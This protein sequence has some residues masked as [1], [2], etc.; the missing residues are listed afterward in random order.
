[1]SVT[2]KVS[3][4]RATNVKTNS[5]FANENE[6]DGVLGK[7]SKKKTSPPVFVIGSTSGKEINRC[8]TSSFVRSVCEAY[9]QHHNLVFKPDDV[10]LAIMVQFSF[11]LE[12]YAEPLRNKFVSHQGQKQLE[13]KGLGTLSSADYEALS[14]QMSDEIAKHIKDPSVRDWAVPNFSTTTKKEQVVGA[15]TLMATMKK[16]FSY[17]FSL[18]CGLPQ[19]TLLGTA[20]DWKAVEERAKRLLEFDNDEHFMNQWYDML[21]PILQQFTLAAQN[22]PDVEFWKHVCSHH[23]NGSGPRYLSGWITVFCVFN[24]SG[25]WNGTNH[26]RY[27]HEQNKYAPLKGWPMLDTNDIPSGVVKVDVVIDD[28]GTTYECEMTAGHDNILIP[29]PD[30][31]QPDVNWGLFIKN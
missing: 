20:E 18:C 4:H 3:D 21:A 19:V 5:L 12:K 17:K 27:K 23:G 15:I 10:W 26:S 8:K 30:T 1:M 13:V 24:D 7:A 29:T 31:V 11:Y 9:N 22:K 2:F 6:Y 16:Y 14:L 25:E 28:N